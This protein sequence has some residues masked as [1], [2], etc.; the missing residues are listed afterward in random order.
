MKDEAESV[1][2]DML[3]VESVSQMQALCQSSRAEGKRIAL[4]PT[5]GYL[6]DGHLEHIR[7]V[8]R[9]VDLVVASIYVNPTQFGA[10]EDLAVYPRDLEGDAAKL[11]GA[12]CDILFLPHSS[13][14]YP[15]GY[16]TY[17]VVE[18]ITSR[19]EGA[20]R[21][22]HFRGVTTVV[23][24]FLNIVM[25]HLVTF[26]QKDAQQ[27]AVLRKMIRDLNINTTV[28]L[29][30]T[31]REHDGLAMSS[32][33]VYLSTEE[34]AE[35]LSISRALHATRDAVVNDVPLDEATRKLRSLLSPALALDY[36]DIINPDTFEL[37][38][39]ED[40]SLLAVIAG[41]IGRTRLIDNMVLR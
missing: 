39:V 18:N 36:A 33:N 2:Y 20:F 9:E 32:R 27:V 23:A 7:R 37:A 26:G 12:G 14:M 30:D 34:R 4:V 3:T 25:P 19:Y 40:R 13:E 24:K 10:G 21:P 31:V 11:Q 1:G 6:H 16:S 22:T 8:R 28:V 35:A 29:V 17:V 15:E 41:R 38:T 5:M